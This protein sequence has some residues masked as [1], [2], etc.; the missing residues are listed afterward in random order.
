MLPTMDQFKAQVDKTVAE[1]VEW[2]KAE[3]CFGNMPLTVKIADVPTGPHGQARVCRKGKA[4]AGF[5]VK[6]QSYHY[7]RDELVAYTEYPTY[8]AWPEIGGFQTTDWILAVDTLIAHEL[9]HVVQFALRE[10][11]SKHP[12]YVARPEYP[13]RLFFDGLGQQESGHGYFFRQIYKRF[14]QR[15]IN[16]RVPASAYTDPRKD[17]IEGNAFEERLAAKTGEHPLTGIKF[18]LK[19]KTYEIAGRNPSNA[20]LFGY[21]VKTPTGSFAKIKLSLI[22]IY[23]PEAKAVVMGNPSLAKELVDLAAAEQV[24]KAANAKSSRTKLRRSMARAA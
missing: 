12:L 11:G 3:F 24:K 2:L 22:C 13:T 14:R 16:H 10:A 9:A 21:M 1:Q 23:S 5:Q 8:N 20:K 4:F 7:L 19:G 15:F 18:N 17:F 6:F